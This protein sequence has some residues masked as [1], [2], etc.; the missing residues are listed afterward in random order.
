MAFILAADGRDDD[1]AGCF[2]RYRAYIARVAPLLPP[3]AS[4]LLMSD[5]YFDFTDRR[6]PHDSWLETAVLRERSSGN[7][8]EARTLA[9]N[10]RLRDAYHDGHIEIEYPLVY[11]YSLAADDSS[12]GHRDW[13]YD[14]LRLSDR[15]RLIHEIEWSG[16]ADTGRWIIEANDIA[17]RWIAD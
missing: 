9:L 11:S 17:F 10:V 6:C 5:W 15:G 4:S 12:D 13:R 16:A 7:R 2:R 14:E 3:G 8:G 1:V